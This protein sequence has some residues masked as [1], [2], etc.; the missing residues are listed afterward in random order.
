M[1]IA[2]GPVPVIP[3]KNTA[4]TPLLIVI[5][6]MGFL[7]GLALGAMSLVSHAASAW[8]SGIIRE[9]TLQIKPLAGHDIDQSLDQAVAWL[10]SVPGIV[11]VKILS[12]QQSARLLE[13]WIGRDIPL[14]VLPLPR[15]VEIEIDPLSPPDIELLA[16]TAQIVIPGAR[17]D[18]HARWQ[19]QLLGLAWVIEALAAAVLALIA[20]A[21]MA[22]VI[23]ATRAGLTA[24]R[25]I[26]DVLHLIGARDFYI[27]CQFHKHFLKIAICG[28]LLGT[29]L[30]GCLFFVLTGLTSQNLATAINT[31]L[32]V[33][34]LALS[35]Q[36]FASLL[37]VPVL[38]SLLVLITTHL[39]VRRTLHRQ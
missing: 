16:K 22:V 38:I 15:L 6:I 3:S 7:S 36:G 18:T 21:T 24:T 23:F 32:F 37:A 9:M 8:N 12:R 11:R 31:T 26:I 33:P 4:A 10:D 28:S 1:S 34:Q 30:A 27:A 35:G 39:T 13:P 25:K 2:A 14:D 17:L 20:L 19:S 5:T 29:A